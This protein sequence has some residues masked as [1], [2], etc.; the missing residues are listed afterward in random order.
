MVNYGYIR[1]EF[2][3]ETMKQIQA[4]LPYECVELFIE[5]SKL[6][7]ESELNR[8]LSLSNP[9]DMIV[10]YHSCA[11]EKNLRNYAK[12]V[13][14]FKHKKI[15]LLSLEEKIDTREQSNYYNFVRKIAEMEHYVIQKKTIRGIKNAREDGRIGGRP[16]IT[17]HTIKHIIH[18]RNT[19]NLPLRQIAEVCNVSLGTVH[20][21]LQEGVRQ[22]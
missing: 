5:D 12:I 1:K 19:Q 11:F 18:L 8:L 2:P 14:K 22:L 20:K 4:L 6:G 21:Y 3:I 7:E 10:V 16:K 9:G 15:S 13:E 17:E